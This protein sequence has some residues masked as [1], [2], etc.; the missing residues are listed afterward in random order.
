MVKV[1]G[2]RLRCW[3]EELSQHF[4]RVIVHVLVRLTP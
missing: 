2:E 1:W 3:D 4:D